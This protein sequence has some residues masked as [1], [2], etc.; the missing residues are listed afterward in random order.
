LEKVLLCILDGFGYREEAFGNATLKSKYI[1]SLFKSQESALLEA[2]GKYVGLPDG[3]FGNSEVG[4]L[5]I[6][7][8]RILK[9]KLLLINDAINSKELRDNKTLND[10]LLSAQN[11][12]FH[13]MGLFS[14]GGTHS[15]INHF[16]WAIRFLR[17]KNISVKAH[18]FLDGR[19]SGYKEGLDT[20]SKAIAEGKISVSEIA[21]V[22]GRFFA[23][24]R[25]K[26]WERT[27]IAYNAIINAKADIK[28]NNPLETIQNF[29]NQNI[30]DETIPP[31]ILGNYCGANPGDSFWT[32]NFRADRI[33]QLLFMLLK[34][35]FRLLNMFSCGKEIDN[36]SSIIFKQSEVKNTLG[37]VLS[38]NKIPQLRVA[39][40]EK[41]AHV[42]YFF[43]GGRDIR[44]DLED[45]ALVPSPK[46][47]NYADMPDMSCGE[48]SN[49]IIKA[50]ENKTHTVIISNFASPDMIG[51]TGNFEA[52]CKALELLDIHLKKIVEIA[53]KNNFRIILTADHGNAENMI[54][55]DGSPIKTH[56]S[57]KV[58]FIL[59]QKQKDYK[60]SRKYGELADIAP[61]VLNIIGIPPPKEMSGDSLIS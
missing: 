33:K 17:S 49:N 36:N 56:A 48:V 47:Q 44:H 37:E 16:S 46:V 61:T 35:K 38:I 11:N 26:N 52:T 32:L 5:T 39:E 28:T 42:T 19:D 30:Y 4:H 41:Y 31:F 50:I 13:L 40:T 34:N 12:T 55:K 25:D 3:Q 54:D 24:D 29:Y 58:P 23:M 22:Q 1:W 51:H 10:F 20:L 60:F 9:Q 53:L 45:R 8:G 7:A 59:V 21:T 6:G 14:K 57:S 2:S 27:E 43:N 18:I 15:D